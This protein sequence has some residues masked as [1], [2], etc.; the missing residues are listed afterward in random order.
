MYCES[1]M[2][3]VNSKC[4]IK[5]RY[6]IQTVAVSKDV[7]I[8]SKSSKLLTKVVCEH[9]GEADIESWKAYQAIQFMDSRFASRHR[10]RKHQTQCCIYLC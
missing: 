5:I 2:S 6:A 8:S 4:Q 1:G 9:E 7:L 10:K 3:L